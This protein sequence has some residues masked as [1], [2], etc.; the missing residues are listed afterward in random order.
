MLAV[1]EIILLIYVWS[2]ED[3]YEHDIVPV[4]INKCTPCTRMYYK[5]KIK[6]I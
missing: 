1:Y 2:A 3:W 5:S 4:T 6:T